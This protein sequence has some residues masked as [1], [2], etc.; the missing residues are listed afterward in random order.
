VVCLVEELVVW[1]GR[2]GCGARPAEERVEVFVEGVVDLLGCVL[3][4]F[5]SGTWVYPFWLVGFCDGIEFCSG[6]VDSGD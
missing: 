6:S 5:E 2:G 4:L 1:G 3:N